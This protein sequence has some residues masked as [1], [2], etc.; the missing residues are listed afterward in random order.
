MKSNAKAAEVYSISNTT[1]SNLYLRTVFIIY[2]RIKNSMRL[3]IMEKKVDWN[4]NSLILKYSSKTDCHYTLFH[5]LC[6][7]YYIY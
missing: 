2:I 7:F 6:E 4:K 5:I 3:L 1:L